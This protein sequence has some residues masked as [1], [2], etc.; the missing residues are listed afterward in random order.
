MVESGQWLFP[1]RGGEP[2][3]DKPP[4]FMW[5]AALTFVVTGQIKIAFL[6]PSA[7]A[8]FGT[9]LL[10][11]DIGRRLWNREVALAAVLVLVLTPQFLLQGKT[12]QIDAL[13]CFWITLGCYGLLRHFFHRAALGLVLHRLCRQWGWASS[14]RGWVFCRC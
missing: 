3:P 13:L 9:V 12:G 2:Y 7:L 11:H 6:L 14:P 5:L 4:V 8:A 1:T 10:V